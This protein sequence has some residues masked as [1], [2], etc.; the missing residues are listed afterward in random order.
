MAMLRRSLIS[1]LV[2]VIVGAIAEEMYRSYVFIPQITPS[3]FAANDVRSYVDRFKTD[4]EDVEVYNAPGV[5]GEFCSRTIFGCFSWGRFPKAETVLTRFTIDGSVVDVILARHCGNVANCSYLEVFKT[6]V[7]P[8]TSTD[9]RELR[10]TFTSEENC[11]EPESGQVLFYRVEF[12]RRLSLH[13]NDVVTAD[14]YANVEQPIYA[15]IF[16]DVWFR[17][18]FDL[19]VDY[20]RHR[21]EYKGR[22]NLVDQLEAAN[23]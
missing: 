16:A 10:K 22:E 8:I 5:I 14:F 12:C 23:E 11:S 2:I 18:E 13:G 9:S 7:S 19:V 3:Y 21:I 1:L 4:Y 20:G 17:V 15:R 6:Y